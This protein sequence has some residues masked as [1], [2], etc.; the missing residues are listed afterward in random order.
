MKTSRILLY[1]FYPDHTDWIALDDAGNAAKHPFPSDSQ[2]IAII[3][4]ED[5]VLTHAVLPK[6]TKSRL[7]Q[8]LPFALEDKLIDDIQDLHFAI[9][10][11]Q[12]NGR[13]P[14]AV[15][16]HKKMIA[17]AERFAEMQIAPSM[18]VPDIFLLPYAEST[19]H[20]NICGA[21]SLVRLSEWEGFGCE[22]ENLSTY[23]QL[24]R[25]EMAS[26]EVIKEEK[27]EL[28][29]IQLLKNARL[30]SSINLL[31]GA[32][33]SK[34]QASRTKKIA[35]IAAIAAA[36]TLVLVFL[37]HLGSFFILRYQEKNL[38]TEINKIYL[39][40]FPAATTITAPRERMQ[41]KWR[42]VSGQADQSSFLMALVAVGN[43]LKLS[44]GI[45]IQHLEFRDRS[46]TLETSAAAFE[47]LDQF[48]VQLTKQGLKAK[49]E[50]AT[51]VG[52]R[53]K[54]SVLI[55]IGT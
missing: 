51:A 40:N 42:K 39:R 45:S 41:K 27:T 49:Q 9:G 52:A 14:V 31:Q 53:V 55:Q 47:N 29:D 21:K 16:S 12:A 7:M 22:T 17:W 19:W 44:P 10:P 28:S 33:H 24:Q 3:P 2:V 18:M 38:S 8:A 50:N 6:L 4:S 54:A 43:A 32:F 46:M 36:S 15:I 11:I 34:P 37:S 23:L 20:I 13:I 30:T 48:T 5:V 35:S 1:F 25:H 26:Q